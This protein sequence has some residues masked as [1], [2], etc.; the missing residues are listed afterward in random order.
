MTNPLLLTAANGHN[1]I[2]FE[3][4]DTDQWFL[5]IDWLR[6]EGFNESGAPVIGVDEGVLPS[7]VKQGVAIAAGFDNW[8]G[9]YLL[10]E[11]DKGDQ[12]I[13]KVANQVSAIDRRSVA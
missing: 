7:Y 2:T 13:L 9:N 10:A 12:V 11:C 1:W 6:R 4:Y 5:A 3:D 8:S